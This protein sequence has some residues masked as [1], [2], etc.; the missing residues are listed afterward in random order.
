[1]GIGVSVQIS[2]V[3]ISEG[4]AVWNP[5]N[6]SP[7]ENIVLGYVSPRLGDRISIENKGCFGNNVTGSAVTV[8]INDSTTP[9]SKISDCLEDNIEGALITG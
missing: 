3:A 4:G 2:E 5:A 6:Y 8:S 1:M 9:K 7:V